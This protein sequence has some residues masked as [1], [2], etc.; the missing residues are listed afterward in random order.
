MSFDKNIL[1]KLLGKRVILFD[2]IDSTNNYAKNNADNL[3]NGTI[4]LAK[5]QTMGKGRLGRTFVSPENKGLYMSMLI[6]SHNCDLNLITVLAA[7]SVYR[8][9]L[10]VCKIKTKIK[11][12][13]DIHYNGKKLC[14]ILTEGVFDSKA[15]KIDRLVIGIGLNIEKWSELPV[16]LENIITT[17]EDIT[18]KKTPYNKLCAE[19]VK[20]IEKLLKKTKTERGKKKILREYKK[21][22][23]VFNKDIVLVS[24]NVKIN[25]KI[26][27]ITDTGALIII[28]NEN[29]EHI[30][31]SGEIIFQ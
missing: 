9:V 5:K 8:S 7:V 6:K 4:I 17:L 10:K 11:W 26:K 25:G 20:N 29:K 30:A 15:N 22:L 13:N 19:I 3:Q 24:G 12:V 16:E 21:N 27:D 14:G 28:D 18:G 1:E 31:N 2:E 23:N